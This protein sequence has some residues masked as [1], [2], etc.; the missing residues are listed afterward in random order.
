MFWLK[1][2]KPR[3]RQEHKETTNEE[4]AEA[5]D[6][7]A[8]EERQVQQTMWLCEKVA[9][10]EKGHKELRRRIVE[11]EARLAAQ[12]EA[13]K[14]EAQRHVAMECA[15]VEIAEH[16]QK[17]TVF[18]E[19]A[20]ARSTAWWRKSR[21]TRAAS[22]RWRGSSRTTSSTSREAVQRRR[23]WRNTSMR[24]SKKMRRICGLG[25]S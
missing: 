25:A 6:V 2:K 7:E 11:T 10:L 16:I 22:R 23:R 19:S 4:A 14:V 5:M 12:E 20:R 17:Q 21:S 1:E 8:P 24:S 15:I 13:R 18:N 3:Q 9:S